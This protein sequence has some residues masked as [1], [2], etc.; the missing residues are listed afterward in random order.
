MPVPSRNWMLLAL[1][2]WSIGATVV[3]AQSSGDGERASAGEGP[4]AEDGSSSFGAGEEVEEEG[5]GAMAEVQ[6]EGN[7]PVDATAAQTRVELEPHE[8]LADGLRRVPGAQVA[9][10]G[11]LGAFRAVRLRGAELGHTELYLGDVPLAGVDQG[12]DLGAYGPSAFSGLTVYRGGAPALLSSGAIGGVL[13]LHPHQSGHRLWALGAAGSFRTGR[14]AVGADVDGA[15]RLNVALSIESTRADYPYRDDGGTAFDPSDDR[16]RRRANADVQRATG[17]VHLAHDFDAGTL[18]TVVLATTRYGGEPGAGLT[19][20][21][22]AKRRDVRLFGALA[23][24]RE[25]GRF[26]TRISAGVEHQ[27]RALSDRFGEIGFGIEETRDR[28]DAA[29]VRAAFEL[30]LL[31]QLE[32]TASAGGRFDGYRPNDRLGP[33]RPNATRLTAH[34]GA[35]LRLHGSM[36]RARAELRAGARFEATALRESD[37]NGS[38]ITT[39]PTYRAAARL[40]FPGPLAIVASVSR[41]RRLP[42]FLELFGD[43]SALVP[44]PDLRSETGRT[45]D[46]G[47]ELAGAGLRYEAALEARAFYLRVNDLIRFIPT[48]QFTAVARNVDEGSLYGAEVGARLRAFGH[49]LAEG[50]MTAMHTDDG[51]GRRLNWRPAFEGLVRGGADTGARGALQNLRLEVAV[52]RRGSFY[53]DPAN[54]VEVG[55]LTWVD[56]GATAHFSHGL[57]LDVRLS[58]VFDRRGADFVGFP[59]PGRRFMATLRIERGI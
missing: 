54:F 17:M 59:L 32:A 2:A 6:S 1:W 44:S 39:Q 19:R 47:I 25:S 21:Q 41:G 35:E 31:D 40:R 18:S 55:G 45:I 4:S 8:S 30:R 22:S 48:S 14:L 7:A 29:F 33:S 12:Y 27:M 15:T 37:Q 53:N 23:F 36:G 10:A 34:G 28:F 38:S 5:F 56:V 50:S 26:R 24:T 20:A 9:S 46:G 16:T 51:G 43:R 13:Q 3:R 42:T 11:A 49:L 57:S 52:R 58:D